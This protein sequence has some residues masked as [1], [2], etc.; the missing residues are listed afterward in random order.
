MP[1]TNPTAPVIKSEPVT[2]PT[3][4]EEIRAAIKRLAAVNDDVW[5]RARNKGRK[6]YSSERAAGYF[7]LDERFEWNAET[8]QKSARELLLLAAHHLLYLLGSENEH[9]DYNLGLGAIGVPDDPQF[10]AGAFFA[11]DALRR[12]VYEAIENWAV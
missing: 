9:A 1:I 11:L 7:F 6:S 3:S 8:Q 10:A 4:P 5:T 12:Q 2:E